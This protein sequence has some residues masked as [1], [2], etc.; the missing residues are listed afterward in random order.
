[1][2]TT[3]SIC[4]LNNLKKKNMGKVCIAFDI[5]KQYT[6]ADFKKKNTLFLWRA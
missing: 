1:M 5:N 6:C 2:S 3:S 4:S